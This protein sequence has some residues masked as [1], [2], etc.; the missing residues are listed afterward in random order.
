MSMRQMHGLIRIGDGPQVYLS[1]Y[2]I[3]GFK[4]QLSSGINCQRCEG[5]VL[6]SQPLNN[7][8]E[9]CCRE[10]HT[11]YSRHFMETLLLGYIFLGNH[12]RVNYR[13]SITRIRVYTHVH[14]DEFHMLENKSIN[15]NH[16]IMKT[17]SFY[18]FE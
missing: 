17:V 12:S 5:T 13:H 11:Q 14:F 3:L 2:F 6:P 8:G 4:I 16:I 7:S 18:F 1:A 9:W 10:C 15:L